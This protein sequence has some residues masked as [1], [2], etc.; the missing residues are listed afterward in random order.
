LASCGSRI[1][2][3]AALLMRL[4]SRIAF[5][6]HDQFGFRPDAPHRVNQIA[7]VLRF[8]LQPDLTAKLTGGERLLI[9]AG[10]NAAKTRGRD[11]EYSVW[12]FPY[13]A[14]GY[15]Y[16]VPMNALQLGVIF[17]R[18]CRRR[19][20][21]AT[22]IPATANSFIF[23]AFVSGSRNLKDFT[24]AAREICQSNPNLGLASSI[25]SEYTEIAFNLARIAGRFF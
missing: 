22:N 9:G 16:F 20:A 12:P 17:R 3:V 6:R 11:F 19:T 4:H 8:E 25:G 5:N 14:V 2:M 10:H 18:R 15:A 7:R 13:I 1:A 23:S 21:A 24:V